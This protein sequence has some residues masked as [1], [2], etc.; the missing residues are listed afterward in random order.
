MTHAH[1]HTC[2]PAA[3]STSY[4][5]SVCQGSVCVIF[6]M[7]WH[8][9]LPGDYREAGFK[10]LLSD[11][12]WYGTL[13]IRSFVTDIYISVSLT[14]LLSVSCLLCAGFR[15][16]EDITTEGKHL[17]MGSI[18]MPDPPER[19]PIPHPQALACGQGFSVRSQSLHSVGGGNCGGGGEDEV[20]SPTSKKQP[21]PKPRRDPATKLSMSSEAV[22]HSPISTCRGERCDGEWWWHFTLICWAIYSC[23]FQCP[24]RHCFSCNDM[25][26]NYLL[27]HTSKLK[28]ELQW[29]AMTIKHRGCISNNKTITIKY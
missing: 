22:D 20:G 6:V 5:A 26:F 15:T 2:E 24:P 21:P 25:T 19:M 16:G 14:S 29:G 23:T 3:M 10:V 8:E 12:N 1:T 13:H 7:S 17:R 11:V 9:Q 28:R 18:T 4:G 27:H